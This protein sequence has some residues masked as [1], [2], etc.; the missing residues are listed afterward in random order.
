MHCDP[1][2]VTHM[3]PKV[4]Q[5]IQLSLVSQFILTDKCD[6]VWAW[7][8]RQRVLSLTNHSCLPGIF[9][10]MMII[11]FNNNNYS[12]P[13]GVRSIVIN[14]S[15]C[16]FVCVSI[17]LSASISL[18]PLDRSAQLLCADPPWSWLGPPPVALCYVM[19]FWFYG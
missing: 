17:C 12:A 5:R 4:S 9:V 13:V 15:V 16:A 10:M 11:N 2:Y 7:T 1:V 3:T 14:P 19:Y 18:E 6:N 8:G